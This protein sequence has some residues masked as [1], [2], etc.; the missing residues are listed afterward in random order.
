MKKT[1]TCQVSGCNEPTLEGLCA[2]HHLALVTEAD[3][4]TGLFSEVGGLD[5]QALLGVIFDVI[6]E[7]S[8]PELRCHHDARLGAC[9]LASLSELPGLGR[10]TW[11]LRAVTYSLGIPLN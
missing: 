10:T 3:L 1:S 2:F 7:E 9:Y 5:G 11:E 8:I 4:F 6:D